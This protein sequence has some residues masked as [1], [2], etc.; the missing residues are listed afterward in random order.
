MTLF[1]RL[2]DGAIMDRI[3]GTALDFLIVAAMGTV[4][5]TAIGSEVAAFV[6]LCMLSVSLNLYF[7]CIYD[8]ID[9]FRFLKQN[10]W[11]STVIMAIIMCFSDFKIFVST[12]S[13]WKRSSVTKHSKD[14]NNWC[15]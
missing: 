13:N 5:V 1:F 10:N 14:I 2:V 4:S 6:I 3:S 9:F 12:I 7:I 11:K 8:C 15:H